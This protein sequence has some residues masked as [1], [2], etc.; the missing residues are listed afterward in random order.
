MTK[1]IHCIKNKKYIDKNTINDLES[2]IT[3]ID[4]TNSKYAEYLD[5]ETNMFDLHEN[6]IKKLFFDENRNIALDIYVNDKYN[7]F[8]KFLS[9]FIFENPLTSDLVDTLLASWNKVELKIQMYILS[10][11]YFY[12]ILFDKKI[13]KLENF[14][15][16]NGCFVAYVYKHMWDKLCEQE[17]KA[18]QYNLY[19]YFIFNIHNLIKLPKFKHFAIAKFNPYYIDKPNTNLNTRLHKY[20]IDDRNMNYFFSGLENIYPFVTDNNIYYSTHLFYLFI[21]EGKMLDL[22]KNDKSV[23]FKTYCT[24]DYF[25]ECKNKFLK[26]NYQMIYESDNKISFYV[27][28]NYITFKLKLYKENDVLTRI[29]KSPYP[30]QRFIIN[31]RNIYMTATFISFLFTDCNKSHLTTKKDKKQI[32]YKTK[33]TNMINLDNNFF[34]TNYVDEIYKPFDKNLI[35]NYVE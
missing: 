3:S 10:S 22:I 21:K 15:E 30:R 27:I 24:D 34:N 13:K 16:K 4:V 35:F 7:F 17:K 2:I 8:S 33:R 19:D 29:C 6:D 18:T 5:D 14:Y 12:K 32:I 26:L 20:N 28:H 31:N 25:I 1:L 9:K 11:E 23:S